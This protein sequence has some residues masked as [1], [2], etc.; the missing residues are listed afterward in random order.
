MNSAGLILF[1]TACLTPAISQGGAFSHLSTESQMC[2]LPQEISLFSRLPI[3]FPRSPRLCKLEFLVPSE[4]SCCSLSN[5]SSPLIG[6]LPKHPLTVPHLFSSTED[7][8]SRRHHLLRSL[9]QL[10]QRPLLPSLTRPLLLPG[11]FNT[12]PP[13]AG[14]RC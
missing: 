2:C 9:Q 12:L 8:Q 10:P 5:L 7:D 13:R 14:G 3:S 6:S 4:S 1:P 11:I